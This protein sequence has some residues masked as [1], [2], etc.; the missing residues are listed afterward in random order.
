MSRKMNLKELE[1]S[2]NY[3]PHR[4]LDP[5]RDKLLIKKER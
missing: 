2:Y 3:D 4:K 1:L 5:K